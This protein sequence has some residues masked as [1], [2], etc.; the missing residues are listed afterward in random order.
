MD[1]ARIYVDFNEMVDY[2][3]VLLSK[4]DTK[5]DSEGNVIIFYEGMPVSIYMDDVD[6]NG[7]VDNLVAEGIAIKQDLSNYPVWQ[8]VKWCCRMDSNGIMNE[9]DLR[10]KRRE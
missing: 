8:H 1:K 5:M 9:S 4:D 7:K 6:G 3:T 10:K 2:N